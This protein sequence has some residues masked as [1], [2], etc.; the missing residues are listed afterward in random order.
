MHIPIVGTN[1]PTMG[2]KTASNSKRANASGSSLAGA[3][4]TGTQQRLFGLLF[5]QPNRS[6]FVTELIELADVGRGAVQRELSRLEAAGLLIVERRGNQKHYRA[7]HKSSIFKEL[8][9][10]VRKTVGLQ[11]QVRWAL[12]PISDQLSLALIYGSV[13]K[14]SDTATSDIDLLF[15]SD[16][17]TLENVY[18]QLAVVEKQL[19][20]SINPTVYTEKE[21]RT[22]RSCGNPFLKRILEGPTSLLQ[23][24]LDA[25]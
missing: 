10:I 24:A 6:F 19:G 8:S 21:F 3:L 18:S 1:I 25:A 4:F 17:L 5:G 22:R 9:S 23:G 7:N 14:R 2:T 15:V 13:A 20:R 16:S 12:E 11:E